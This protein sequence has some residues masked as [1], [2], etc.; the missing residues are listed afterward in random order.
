MLLSC[1]EPTAIIPAMRRFVFLLLIVLLP[2]QSVWASAAAYCMHEANAA[3][4]SHFG[5]HEHEH[6]APA[7][8][9]S[10]GSLVQDQDCMICHV[11]ACPSV[12]PAT[13]VVVAPSARPHSP[14][15]ATFAVASARVSE[16]ERPNWLRLA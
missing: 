11:I 15:A 8:P 4:V 7:D 9:K 16:P 10:S 14:P 3:K 2:L 12:L 6:R 5:H 1:H 13:P